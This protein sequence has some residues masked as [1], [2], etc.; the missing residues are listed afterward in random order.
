MAADATDRQ[1]C[2]DSMAA[3]RAVAELL[4]KN[5]ELV[6]A[7]VE[8][9]RRDNNGD[10]EWAAGTLRDLFSDSFNAADE[11]AIA[12]AGAIAPLIELLRRGSASAKEDAAGALRN[13]AD[14]DANAAA[15]VAA[16]GIAPLEQLARD[17]EGKAKE[18]ASMALAKVRAARV[19]GR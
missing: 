4:A 15:I 1:S 2:M 16:G 8:L 14:N 5:V 17:G 12:A 6:A 11:V 19:A 18:W 3:P 9:L 7:C 10:K 13:L